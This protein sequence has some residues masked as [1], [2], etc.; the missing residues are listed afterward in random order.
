[1][2]EMNERRPLHIPNPFEDPIR[3]GLMGVMRPAMERV[4]KI[5]DLND[6]YEHSVG[7][8]EPAKITAN[9]LEELGARFELAAGDLEQIPTE[10][11]LVVVANHP[12]GGVEGLVIDALLRQVRPDVKTI[13]NFLL[14]SLPAMR[15]RFFFV[16]PFDRPQSAKNNLRSLREALRWVKDGH[17]LAVFPAGEVSH[18]SIK[19]RSISDP[20]WDESAARIALRNKAPVLPIY[21]DGR[22]SLRFQLLGLVHPRLRTIMLPAETLRKR[23]QTIRVVP[24][25]LI[26]P[27]RLAEFRDSA[28]ANSYLRVRTYLLKNRLDAVERAAKETANRIEPAAGGGDEDDYEL[29]LARQAQEVADLPED[30]LLS[31]SHPFDVYVA[32][33]KQIPTLLMEIARLRE[34]TFRAAGEGTG[35]EIDTDQF[36]H[37]YLHLFVW[38]REKQEVVGAY[39]LGPTDEIL[40][41][42]GV[43]GLY[44]STLFNYGNRL[45]R[46]IDPALELGR[47]FVRQEYQRSHSP[48]LLLWR[49]LGRFACRNPR[50]RKL[51]GPVSISNDY[52]SMTKQLLIQFLQSTQYVS[53]LGRLIKPR[54]PVRLR[55]IRHWDPS[56]MSVVVKDLEDVDELVREIE[57]D[58]RS[59]PVLV[60]QYLKL[61]AKL[62]GFNVDPEFGDVVDGL[63]LVDLTEVDRRILKFYMGGDG[64]D[65][66][67]AAHGLDGEG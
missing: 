65:Q 23:D 51:F 46:Q 15:D 45:M 34:L 24:G 57:A 26:S 33:A 62:L 9:M 48:L 61:N 53:V 19:K 36:D 10:G 54:R 27:Q 22:N 43:D 11:P 31:S 67:L 39:R 4:L 52:Q 63:M 3:R 66:F 38:H 56:A 20:P 64:A 50:Y 12:F 28:E 8:G 41:K 40:P 17:A 32:R 42:Y 59:V 14:S 5:A 7:R 55:A 13:A 44:T 25:S 21:F 16:D 37:H 2:N 1:M 35:Q 58:R 18:A 30:A 47:S 6:V 49:G 60:R 29:S